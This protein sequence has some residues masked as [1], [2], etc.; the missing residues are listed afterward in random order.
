MKMGNRK[1]FADVQNDFIK[2]V[3]ILIRELGKSLGLYKILD[4]LERKLRYEK[5]RS[6]FKELWNS[7]YAIPKPVFEVDD[8]GV[9]FAG[10]YESFPFDGESRTK[11][12]KGKPHYIYANPLVWIFKYER[13]QPS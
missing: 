12:Y 7:I 11:T 5:C 13:I 10:Y 3:D 6:E 8:E 1:T 2:A 4:W 9:K